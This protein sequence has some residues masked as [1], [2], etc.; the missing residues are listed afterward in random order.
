MLFVVMAVLRIGDGSCWCCRLRPPGTLSGLCGDLGGASGGRIGRKVQGCCPVQHVDG[1]P[2]QRLADAQF[3]EGGLGP[4]RRRACRFDL[5]VGHRW[6]LHDVT[7]VGGLQTLQFTS[8]GADRCIGPGKV[9]G[10]EPE[11]SVSRRRTLASAL[12]QTIT[13]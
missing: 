6:E 1:A 9:V 7:A 5:L 10:T 13:D 8:S 11:Y 3:G 4:L 12:P 2:D